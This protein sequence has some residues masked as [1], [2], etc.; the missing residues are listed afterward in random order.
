MKGAGMT[1][2]NAPGPFR[3]VGPGSLV[4]FQCDKCRKYMTPGGR[5]QIKRGGIPLGWLCRECV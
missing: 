4:T 2:S 1:K 3:A 5:K